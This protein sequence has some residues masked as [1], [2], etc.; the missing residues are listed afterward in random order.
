M[1]LVALFLAE[2]GGRR[3][4]RFNYN[5]NFVAYFKMNL[6]LWRLP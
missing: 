3:G 1:L 2:N 4:R 6:M 5:A